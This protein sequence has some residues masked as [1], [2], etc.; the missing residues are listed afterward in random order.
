MTKESIVKY[1]DAWYG[2]SLMLVA[3]EEERK[4]IKLGMLFKFIDELVENLRISLGI[5]EEVNNILMT[6]EG[7]ERI[8]D[9]IAKHFGVE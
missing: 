5:P 6:Y 9:V 8:V 7:D 3:Y 2:A 4:E 1:V